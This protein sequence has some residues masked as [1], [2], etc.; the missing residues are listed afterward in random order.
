LVYEA[1]YD[2]GAEFPG[3]YIANIAVNSS[4]A[5]LS[6]IFAENS[7]D[8]A[9]YPIVNMNT[10]RRGHLSQSATQETKGTGGF[11]RLCLNTCTKTLQHQFA[12]PVAVEVAMLDH[13][14]LARLYRQ[15]QRG[16][17]LADFRR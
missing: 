1:V 7:S 12:H 17:R 14:H 6:I 15:M 10:T 13:G 9:G 5:N 16:S 3:I 11:R 2:E 8:K 4:G